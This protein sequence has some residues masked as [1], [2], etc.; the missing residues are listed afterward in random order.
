MNLNNDKRSLGRDC[1]KVYN[2]MGD[3]VK[4]NKTTSYAE[5]NFETVVGICGC[6][7]LIWSG[8]FGIYNGF[9]SFFNKK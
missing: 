8:L 4:N 9:K 2:N 1:G 5:K 6:L 7:A 3:Y